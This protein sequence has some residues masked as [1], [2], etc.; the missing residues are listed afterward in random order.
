MYDGLIKQDPRNESGKDYALTCISWL[1][2]SFEIELEMILLYI[3]VYCNTINVREDN[4]MRFHNKNIYLRTLM[5]AFHVQKSTYLVYFG[6]LDI[7]V[8]IKVCVLQY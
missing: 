2:S 5:F 3:L 8:N 1:G 6:S 4:I 7:F